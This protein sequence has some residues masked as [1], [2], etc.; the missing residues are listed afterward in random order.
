VITSPAHPHKYKY[1]LFHS[2][3][4]YPTPTPTISVA[5]LIT[6]NKV[7]KSYETASPYNI[8]SLEEAYT[9]VEPNFNLFVSIFIVK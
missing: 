6:V 8:I 1:F 5:T 2:I 7:A 3:N 4:K 9:L